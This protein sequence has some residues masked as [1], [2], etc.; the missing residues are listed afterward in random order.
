VLT[1]ADVE[2]AGVVA[3]QG[4][5]AQPLALTGLAVEVLAVAGLAVDARD[6]AVTAGEA[7]RREVELALGGAPQVP[8]LLVKAELLAV[9][10]GD[11]VP[12]ALL[13]RV[14]ERVAAVVLG[15]DRG[16][17]ARKSEYYNMGEDNTRKYLLR[18][19]FHCF[20]PDK[21][22]YTITRPSSWS[23][24]DCKE[25]MY[26]PAPR[27]SIRISPISR[28]ETMKRTLIRR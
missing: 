28:F 9:L 19:K 22:N 26:V 25:K 15:L 1:T 12:V 7:A 5:G 21:S 8:V 18:D 6:D 16:V 20:T 17:A 11:L 13:P 27:S 10:E 3:G 23:Q 24:T 2:G 4:A 14:D